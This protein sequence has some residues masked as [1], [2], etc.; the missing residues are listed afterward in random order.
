[1]PS[2]KSLKSLKTLEHIFLR[3]PSPVSKGL[4]IHMHG[5]GD[6]AFGWLDGFIDDTKDYRGVQFGKVAK[7]YDL[8]KEDNNP[9]GERNTLHSNIEGVDV[10]LLTSPVRPVTINGGMPCNSWYDLLALSA[11]E[12]PK[13]DIQQAD[14]SAD[15][16]KKIIDKESKKYGGFSKIAI[17]GF[18]QGCAMALHTGLC[19]QDQLAAILGMSGYLLPETKVFEKNPEVRLYHG[20]A[21]PMVPVDR[22]EESYKKDGFLNRQNVSF[23]KIP[24]MEHTVTIQ[25]LNEARIFIAKSLTK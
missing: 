3:S 23:T 5:L 24:G 19:Y 4:Y 21:D 22:A 11:S 17:G 10:M 16:I 1:M 7:N 14:Q 9:E 6:T 18:S 12:N 8:E 25:E 2:L 15:F 13:Q 20:T